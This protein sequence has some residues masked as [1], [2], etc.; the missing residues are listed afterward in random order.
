MLQVRTGRG[1]AVTMHHVA[2]KS[3][4]PLQVLSAPTQEHKLRSSHETAP[5]DIT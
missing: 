3:P 5:L 4:I 2:E 1:A